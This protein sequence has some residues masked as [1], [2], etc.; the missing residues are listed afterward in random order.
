MQDQR[1]KLAIDEGVSKGVP[2]DFITYSLKRGGWPAEM[3]DL[4]EIIRLQM[5]RALYPLRPVTDLE[6]QFYD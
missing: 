1:L 2:M 4:A 6:P 5:V 3:V